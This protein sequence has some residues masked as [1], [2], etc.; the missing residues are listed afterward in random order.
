MGLRH[1]VVLG[2]QTGG[3]VVGILSRINF[4]NDFIEERTGCEHLMHH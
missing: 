2:G 1:L 3:E 4:L